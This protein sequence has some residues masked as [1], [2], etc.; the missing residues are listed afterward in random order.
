MV[1]RKQDG[2]QLTSTADA[3]LP[4]LRIAAP[5]KPFDELPDLKECWAWAHG[6]AAADNTSDPTRLATR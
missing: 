4:V 2:V 5:A 3:P 6:Q 1:V